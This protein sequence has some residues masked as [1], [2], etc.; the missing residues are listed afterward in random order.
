M[1]SLFSRGHQTPC[2]TWRAY[3]K[4]LDGKV[5][6]E[7]GTQQINLPFWGEMCICK[8]QDIQNFGGGSRRWD[9]QQIFQLIISGWLVVSFIFLE[10]SPRKLVK[11][12]PFLTI[13]IFH[14]GWFQHQPVVVTFLGFMIHRFRSSR[15]WLTHFVVVAIVFAWQ[16][17]V[18]DSEK[19]VNIY[20]YMHIYKNH[21]ESLLGKY[22]W[23]TWSMVI[24]LKQCFLKVAFRSGWRCFLEP[25]VAN[26][27]V[28]G[29]QKSDGSKTSWY[30]KDMGV[31][32]NNG[33][34]KWMV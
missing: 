22:P 28:D 19:N 18:D 27:P 24:A 13:H 16:Q 10:C 4:C 31:S 3:G 14:R 25:G 1:S 6:L 30:G 12:N 33:T 21:W 34:P 15:A 17:L 9:Q 23:P 32:K 26:P 2:M 7:F 11:M 8:H 20:I 29:N 5:G